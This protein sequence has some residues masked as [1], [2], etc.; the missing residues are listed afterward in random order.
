MASAR[1]ID[2]EDLLGGPELVAGMDGGLLIDRINLWGQGIGLRLQQHQRETE[3]V[4]QQVLGTQA[5]LGFTVEQAKAALAAMHD[6]FCRAAAQLHAQQSQT[7][8]SQLATLEQVVLAAR[9]RFQELDERL[10]RTVGEVEAKWASVERWA[11]GETARVTSV[12]AGSAAGATTTAPPPFD[13]GITPVGSPMLSPTALPG[14]EIPPLFV[15]GGG[16]ANPFDPWAGAA[17]AKPRP[18][19]VPYPAAG[20]G[21]GPSAFSIS[22]PTGGGF[23]PPSAVRDLRIDNRSWNQNKQLEAG[24]GQEAFLVWKDR[25]LSYLSRDRPDVRKML[26]WA[27]VQTREGLEAGAATQA[28]VLGMRDL[29][30]VDYVLFDGVKSIIT[31][32]LLGRAR[33]CEERGLELWRGLCAEWHGSAPQYKHAKARRFQDPPD[34]GTCRHFGRPS[35]SGSALA[36]KSAQPASMC[37]TGLRARRS[38]S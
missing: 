21:P 37:Q 23:G 28:G 29:E 2:V 18:S 7:G 35:Q 34:A 1:A 9:A 13:L 36:R 31:D 32:S 22:T 14:I 15:G 12:L 24:A 26:A 5:A 25:A 6:D 16:S 38:R 3:A 17:S 10:G 11:A 19:F 27:E 20:R 4:R 8:L 33:G 30:A